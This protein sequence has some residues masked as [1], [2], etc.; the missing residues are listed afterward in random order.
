MGHVLT[1]SGTPSCIQRTP[2]SPS[3]VP[4]LASPGQEGGGGR[5]A[6]ARILTLPQPA[7]SQAATSWGRSPSIL[8]RRI[9]VLYISA[10]HSG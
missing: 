8:L 9:S 5:K 2:R 3:P 10:S 4:L 1:T 7:S 6:P